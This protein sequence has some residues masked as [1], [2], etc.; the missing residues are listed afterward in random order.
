[1][2]KLLFLGFIILVGF[3]GGDMQNEFIKLNWQYIHG[4]TSDEENNFKIT[5]DQADFKSNFPEIPFFSRVVDIK[6]DNQDLL[7]TIEN[8]VFEELDFKI[9]ENLLQ[10]LGTDIQLESYTLYSNGTKKCYLEIIP[11]KKIAGKVV[12]LK[13]FELKTIP[14]TTKSARVAGTDWKSE[15]VL[16]Q[17]KWVKISTN[18]EG[19]YKIPYSKLIAWGF[20]NPANVSV[21]GAGGTILS[22][23]PGT[24][25]FDDL[26]QNTIWHA[27]NNGT[28]CLFFYAKGVTDWNFDANDSLFKHRINDYSKNG[29]YFLT[30]Q[31]G[32]VNQIATLPEI[33]DVAMQQVTSGNAYAVYERE[34]ENILPLG[35]GRR[36]YGEKFKNNSTKTISFDVPD[37]VDGE[38]MV[39]ASAVGRSYQTSDMTIDVGQTEFGRLEFSNVAVGSETAY[40]A[41][42][43][44]IIFPV[45]ISSDALSLRL[46]YI[47][48]ESSS[49]ID[50]NAKAWLDY[51]EINYRR[52]I[53]AG[54]EPLYWRDINSVSDGNII[55]IKIENS[56]S[57]TRLFDVTDPTEIGEVPLVLVGNMATGK[58]PSNELREYVVFKNSGTFTEPEFVS[59]VENQNLHAMETPEFLIITHNNFLSSAER[60]ANFHR[61]FD[62]MNVAVVTS[63]KVFNEFSSG[64]KDATGIRNFI[65]M[66]YDRGESLKYVLLFGDGSYD[67]RNIKSESKSFI[68][69]YQSDNSL[70][71][72]GSFVSDDYFVILDAGESINKGAMDLGIGR[73]PASTTYE[74]DLVVDK[75]ENYYGSESLGAWRNV[76]CFIA[77]DQDEGQPFHTYD[78]ESYAYKVN[79]NYG[80]FVTDKIYFDAF[81]QETNSG[82]Q[83]YPDVTNEINNRVKEGVLVLNYVGHANEKYMAHEKVLDISNVNSWSNKNNLPIFVTATCEFSRYD[84]DETSIGEYVLMNPNGGGIGLFSTTRLA[85]ANAN[86]NLSLSFYSF[87]FET[88]DE[89]NRYRMGDIIRL[90]KINIANDINKRNFSLLADPALRLS[91]PKYN[92][93]TTAING[94]DATIEPDTVGTLQRVEIEGIITDHFGKKLT[95]FSGDIEISVFD[96]E[97]IMHTLGNDGDKIKIPFKVQKNIIYKGVTDVS[98]GDFTFSFIVPKDI[99]YELG[100]GKIVYYANNGQEDAHGAFTN[101]LIGGSYDGAISDTQGPEI[102]LYMDNNSFVSGGKTG[103]STMLLAYLSDENGINTIGTGIGHDITAILDED[104]SNI[105]V[106]NNYYKADKNDYTSGKIEF[107][108]QNLS[109]GQHRIKLKVWD[110]ANNSSE[111]EI[112]FEVSGD[113]TISN[114]LTQPNP[115]TEYTFFTFEH[116]QPGVTLDVVIEIFDQ[117]GKRI[118]YINQQVGSSGTISNPIRWDFAESQTTLRSGIYIYRISAKNNEGLITSR[119]G[120]LMVSR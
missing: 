20:S 87:V 71:Q 17:G 8:P 66:F 9:D 33:Q 106:L 62:N 65:K 45:A 70:S 113:F 16:K 116:N 94:K 63:D 50:E 78:S 58:R 4:D 48:D 22:E 64:R 114:V 36:W 14:V 3:S 34:L 35:S 24:I 56:T 28:D 89:G 120:K 108:F 88:D 73:I 83:S 7:F 15:S 101:F 104:Y 77:D 37:N 32:S 54:N 67:N 105:M 109:T 41:N 91:Y 103:K 31:T 44:T 49:D 6:N 76:V 92:V 11:L 81:T 5:F 25:E 115:A 119:S 117:M 61:S 23:D 100:T 68:P 112:E 82:N 12:V 102:D 13:S 90:A 107:P 74:A 59:D 2:K 69:T 30:D 79:Q 98:N 57:D 97:S 26:P 38:V 19:I 21:Y 80:G 75:I 110:V 53:I 72:T 96:K 29:Y 51:L 40:Y 27:K 52:K 46:K 43:K 85:W 84:A 39:R 93:V 18:Q 10:N 42:E 47:T 60:L 55:E 86:R 118:N 111:A 95:G 1:M 99:S